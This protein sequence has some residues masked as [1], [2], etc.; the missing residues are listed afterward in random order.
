MLAQWSAL[1]IFRFLHALVNAPV[2]LFLLTLGIMLFRPPDLRFYDLDRIAF[3]V[4]FFSVAIRILVSG[5]RF[6]LPRYVVLPMLA[7]TV[8][9]FM[10]TVSRPYDAELWSVFAAKWLVP[11]VMFCLAGYVF[12]NPRALGKLEVF[13]WI[14]LIYLCVIAVLFLFNIRDFIFPRYILDNNIGIHFDRARGP[15]LQAVA[16]GMI[17]NLLAL[18]ALDSFR[19]HKL[20]FYVAGGLFVLV[21]LAVLATKTRAVWLSFGLSIIVLALTSPSRKIRTASVCVAMA[22][23]L[24]VWT[25]LG[26]S[27]E[28]ASLKTRLE[29]ASPVEFREVLY[30]T[31]WE[32]FREKP[33]LGWPAQ[34]IQPQLDQRINEFH[35]EAFYFHNTFLEIGVSYG[36][37]GLGLYLWMVIDLLSL[38]HPINPPPQKCV[39]HFIDDGFRPLWPLLV[40]VYLLNACF[41]V[42]NYQFVNGFFFT[43]AGI[44]AAQNHRSQRGNRAFSYL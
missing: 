4:L 8:L 36:V 42:M 16:N 15:F 9:A 43:I 32:M 10:A 29:E 20:P 27:D 41:V 21:P 24:G 26:N 44:I 14:V 31:G 1:A 17:L 40:A 12:D 30:Q 2:E 18:I 35:Q 34:K 28:H 11:L 6:A 3:I 7:M 22:A 25:I 38:R 23:G 37:A 33:L 5:G 19:R 39:E 13:S